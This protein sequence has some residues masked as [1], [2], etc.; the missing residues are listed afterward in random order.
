M[1][2]RL[3]KNEKGLTLIEL[4]AVVVILGI[5]AAIAVPSIGSIIDNTKRDAHIANAQQLVSSTK[6]YMAAENPAATDLSEGITLTNLKDKNYISD[7]KDPSGND[8]NPNYNPGTTLVKVTKSS[9]AYTYKVTVIGNNGITYIE[10]I[11]ISTLARDDVKL[12]GDSSG[13]GGTGG[14]TGGT[15]GTE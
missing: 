4:L 14:D 8:S 3:W 15:G 10:D 5:I 11:D 7:I 2:K 12:P 1:F 6:L 13:T 9:N